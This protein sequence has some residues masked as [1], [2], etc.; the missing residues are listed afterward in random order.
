M[1]NFFMAI[2]VVVFLR[3]RAVAR[4]AKLKHILEDPSVLL[5]LESA[6]RLPEHEAEEAWKQHPY[7]PSRAPPVTAKLLALS[8]TVCFHVARQ[9]P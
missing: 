9:M 6:T 7:E 2:S 8:S 4:A 5:A 3:D 1:A